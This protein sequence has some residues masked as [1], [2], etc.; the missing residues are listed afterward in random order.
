M[1]TALDRLES[2]LRRAGKT[3]AEA[4]AAIVALQVENRRLE[5]FVADAIALLRSHQNKPL[6]EAFLDDLFAHKAEWRYVPAKQRSG[7]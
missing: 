1:T 5:N 6:V 3:T 2:R 4:A 7:S